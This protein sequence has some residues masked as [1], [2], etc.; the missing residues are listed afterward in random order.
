MARPAIEY[1]GE[2][3]EKTTEELAVFLNDANIKVTSTYYYS[4]DKTLIVQYEQPIYSDISRLD[5]GVEH[6]HLE[7]H[8]E[9]LEKLKTLFES[10]P[11]AYKKVRKNFK[12]LD[13]CVTANQSG[14]K[15]LL[16][17]IGDAWFNN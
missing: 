9:Q 7:L 2:G 12:I 10:Y 16:A 6:N 13:R 3:V 8:P 1:F 5:L 11:S 4:K 17:K 14:W 15:G